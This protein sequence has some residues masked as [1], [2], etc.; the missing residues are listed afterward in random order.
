MIVGGQG[1]GMWGER[2][3]SSWGVE[4]KKQ[5]AGVGV[6]MHFL[7]TYFCVA[8]VFSSKHVL[9][10]ILKIH[11]EKLKLKRYNLTSASGSFSQTPTQV[12]TADSLAGF[13]KVG[14]F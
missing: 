6:D 1:G 7:F 11:R 3:F 12:P 9:F 8:S 2:T 13:L 10:D 14:S 5:V 4:F